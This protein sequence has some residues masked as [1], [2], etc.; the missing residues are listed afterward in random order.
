MSSLHETAYPR[1]RSTVTENELKEY[2]TP[3]PEEL[4]LIASEKKPILRFGFILNLK[5]LQRLGYFVPLASAPPSI[6]KHVLDAIGIIAK[7]QIRADL[8]AADRVNIDEDGT[9]D[10]DRRDQASLRRPVHT[11]RMRHTRQD[12][13]H[14]H[15]KTRVHP[16]RKRE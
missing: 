11:G 2:Y 12:G 6:M 10:V 9:P 7:G 16:P 4:K 1:L 14:I 5:L 13:P 8:E 3:T 15:H